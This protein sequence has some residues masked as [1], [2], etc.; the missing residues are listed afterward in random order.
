M[1]DDCGP[2]QKSRQ[3]I[4]LSKGFCTLI[5]LLFI[6]SSVPKLLESASFGTSDN[7]QLLVMIS[8]HQEECIGEL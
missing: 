5:F 1:H 6:L 2:R 7:L 8:D 4:T 3:E